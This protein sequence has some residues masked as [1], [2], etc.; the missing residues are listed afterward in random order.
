MSNGMIAALCPTFRR[1]GL[2]GNAAACFLAQRCELPRRMLIWEDGGALEAATIGSIQIV[3]SRRFPD[4]GS[5][6]NALAERA[7]ELWDPDYLAIWEDDDIYLTWHLETSI[8]A[9]IQSGALWAKPSRVWSLY[10]GRLEEEPAAGRFH[11][12]LVL[13]RRAWEQVPWPTHGRADFDQEFMRHLQEECGPPADPL[14]IEPRPGYIFR[15]GSTRSYHAQHFMR[16]TADITWYETVAEH[17]PELPSAELRIAFDDE[18]AAILGVVRGEY[19][20]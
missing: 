11:G 14:L 12:S 20:G 1:P 5:K 3:T 16:G 19:D 18:T 7:I 15:Y 4:L 13:T 6:Y 2:T 9:M 10:T 17:V 8:V